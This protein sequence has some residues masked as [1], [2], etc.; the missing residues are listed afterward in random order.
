M[1]EHPYLSQRVS[2]VEIEQLERAVERRR[3][4]KEHAD[5]IVRRPEGAVVGLIR[6]VTGRRADVVSR[7]AA[8]LSQARSASAAGPCEAAVAR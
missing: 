1:F 8:P 5:Q 4:L 7:A 2:E 3:W 6:R